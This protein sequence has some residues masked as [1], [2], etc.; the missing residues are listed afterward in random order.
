[1]VWE[2]GHLGSSI[3]EGIEEK[4][5]EARETNLNSTLKL[6]IQWEPHR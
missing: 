1:M 6:E 4:K 3:L 2:T 5:S